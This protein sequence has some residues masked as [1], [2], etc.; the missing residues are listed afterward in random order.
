M[1]Y[2]VLLYR[3]AWGLLVV[4]FV[5]GAACV[6]VPK[7]HHLRELQRKRDSLHEDNGRTELITRDLRERQQRFQN[8][9]SF[10]ER[11]AREAGMIRPNE[12][13]FKY[14]VATPGTAEQ[15]G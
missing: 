14:S 4:L 9:P 5:V 2:W 11:T 13:V 7:G 6:F 3:F 1:N 8:D 15:D 10:V 12:V